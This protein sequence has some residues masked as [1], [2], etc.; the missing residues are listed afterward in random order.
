MATLTAAEFEVRSETDG[1]DL[2]YA[3]PSLVVCQDQS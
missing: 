1:I 2:Y 3:W